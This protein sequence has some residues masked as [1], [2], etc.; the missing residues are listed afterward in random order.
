MPVPLR[1]GNS[2]RCGLRNAGF[3]NGPSDVNPFLKLHPSPRSCFCPQS[4]QW[5]LLMGSDE[6]RPANLGKRSH[7]VVGCPRICGLTESI[8]PAKGLRCGRGPGVRGSPPCRFVYPPIAYSYAADVARP[9]RLKAS[10]ERSIRCSTTASLR[11]R[12]T[13]ALR[14]PARFATASAH[15]FRA[16][17]LTGRV[18]IT[19]AAS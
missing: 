5:P 3:C 8:V 13:F 9:V 14:M 7:R 18:S 17:P 10:P 12:A 15:L 19:F 11:A 2:L 4:A 1:S 6:D 16:E